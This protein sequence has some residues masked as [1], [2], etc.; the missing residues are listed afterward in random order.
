MCRNGAKSEP[1][2]ALSYAIP[3]PTLTTCKCPANLARLLQ[4]LIRMPCSLAFKGPRTP[5]DRQGLILKAEVA[6]LVDALASGASELFARGGSSP[7]LGTRLYTPYLVGVAIRFGPPDSSH[8][9]RST[10]LD[11]SGLAVRL[12]IGCRRHGHFPSGGYWIT[13][14]PGCRINGNV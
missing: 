14:F 7:L 13:P 12:P 1:G 2:Q 5:P 10:N 4:T 3:C 11:Y 9:R 8:F 6:E